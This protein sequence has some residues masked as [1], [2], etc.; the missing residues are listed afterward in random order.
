[1][2]VVEICIYF[3]VAIL[4][5]TYPILLQVVARIDDKYGNDF[6]SLFLKEREYLWFKRLLHIALILILFYAI[7]RVFNVL[8]PYV[9]VLILSRIIRFAILVASS[10]LLY[11]LTLLINK[12]LVYYNPQALVIYMIERNSAVISSN[13]FLYFNALFYLLKYSILAQNDKVVKTITDTIYKCF[14]CCPVKL[15]KKSHS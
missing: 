6:Y 1:M 9:P 5:L 12:V 7:V 2:S 11:Y 14:H 13:Q 8:W 10:V 3:I 15:E 4:G